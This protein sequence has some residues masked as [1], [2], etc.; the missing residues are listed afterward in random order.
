MRDKMQVIKT[1]YVS[2]HYTQ[3][4]KYGERMLAEAHPVHLAYLNFY[5]AL[6]HDTLAREATLKN[7]YKELSLAEKHYMA[8]IA[9]LTPSD[10]P[11]SDA[12]EP[13]SP[14]SVTS[15]EDM[16][17]KARRSSNAG[18]F[19]STT[20]AASSA[21]SFNPDTDMDFTPSKGRARYAFPT[22]PRDRSTSIL[23]TA[24]QPSTTTITSSYSRPQ[25]PSEHH[26][27][28]NTASFTAMLHTHLSNVQSLKDKTSVPSVR[29][30]FPSPKPSPTSSRARCS[31][32]LEE[33][34]DAMELVRRER[35]ARQ[36]R[37]RFDP[38]GVM[39]L[40]GEALGELVG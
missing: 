11:K 17:W 2:R 22:P 12:E 25:T 28:S 38:R 14:T 24:D 4:A 23:K 31:Q 18:S 35:R 3:C 8:A 13:S 5:T 1:A 20:S 33:D 27:A 34:G 6:S 26:L 16:I 40:C 21:T 36:W 19:D 30:A 7:R 32:W 29:F 39:R 10:A 15:G 37:P 9:A